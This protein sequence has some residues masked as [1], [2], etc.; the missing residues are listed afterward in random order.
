MAVKDN[1]DEL[2][3]GNNFHNKSKVQLAPVVEDDQEGSLFSSF[4]TKV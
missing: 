2:T 4:Y 1:S 3:L